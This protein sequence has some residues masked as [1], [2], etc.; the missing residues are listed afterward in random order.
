MLKKLIML[1]IGG[2]MATQ[3]IIIGVNL[4]DIERDP[5]WA[6]LVTGKIGDVTA[7]ISMVMV[8]VGLTL[9]VI[10][11]IGLVNG[12]KKEKLLTDNINMTQSR[13]TI[14]EGNQNSK[15]IP[16]QLKEYKELFR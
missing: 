13:K 1:I 9:I 6:W 14:N 15:T 8:V 10:S 12:K 3:F 7:V 2:I 5:T 16:Q 11:V 4:R